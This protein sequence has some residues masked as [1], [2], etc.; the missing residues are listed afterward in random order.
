MKH[1]EFVPSHE[2]RISRHSKRDLSTSTVNQGGAKADMREA[3][4]DLDEAM[5]VA[6]G[7]VWIEF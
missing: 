2:K 6:V 3:M 4:V 1:R 7:S 5:E